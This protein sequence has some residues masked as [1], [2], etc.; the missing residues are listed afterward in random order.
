[1]CGC[2][3]VPGVRCM[4]VHQFKSKFLP[5]FALE[6]D[7]NTHGTLFQCGTRPPVTRVSRFH[8][9]LVTLARHGNWMRGNPHAICICVNPAFKNIAVL[10]LPLP[11]WL[12]SSGVIIP[13]LTLFSPSF[14]MFLV[15]TFWCNSRALLP[16]LNVAEQ[17]Y[18]NTHSC[19]LCAPYIKIS[20]RHV[21]CFFTPTTDSSKMW[22]KMGGHV[23]FLFFYFFHICITVGSVKTMCVFLSG[24]GLK[25]SKMLPL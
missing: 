10:S 17:L 24:N 20:G 7:P 5:E 18:P 15:N 14:S 2:G 8:W 4:S 6:P 23:Q 25:S 3:F 9:E 19:C 11:C 1:M 12:S 21:L 13:L 16:S 22:G